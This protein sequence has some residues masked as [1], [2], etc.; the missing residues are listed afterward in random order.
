M[1][2]APASGTI[3]GRATLTPADGAVLA[4]VARARLGIFNQGRL[5]LYSAAASWVAAI[6]AYDGGHRSTILFLLVSL[7]L[8][9]AALF[10]GAGMRRSF[11]VRHG[12]GQE[13]EITVGDD[14]VTIA[15][16]GMRVDYAWT[17]FD[18]AYESPEYFALRSPADV[19]AL[20][21]RAFAPDDVPRVRAAIA[22]RLPV[23][24]FG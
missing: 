3:V 7:V 17:R 13:R 4:R 20:P 9:G 14:G 24:P 11:S 16:P 15:E 18:R 10:A 23:E 22:S 1:T 5:L 21:K 2:D 19:V 12:G 8:F 6:L